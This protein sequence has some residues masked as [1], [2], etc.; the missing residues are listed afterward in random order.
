ML[1]LIKNTFH[2]KI[3]LQCCFCHPPP[4]PSPLL[5]AFRVCSQRR[6]LIIRTT[7][8]PLDYVTYFVVV[9]FCFYF[10]AILPA[11]ATTKATGRY[12]GP[13]ATDPARKK[14]E[15]KREK[16]KSKKPSHCSSTPPKNTPHDLLQ[17]NLA[18][19][20]RRGRT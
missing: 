9:F 16:G 18:C 20:L 6:R 3:F 17:L 12:N 1:A 7:H 8:P 13:L 5:C 11:W 15:K 19:R 4:S 10:N 2:R 14:K